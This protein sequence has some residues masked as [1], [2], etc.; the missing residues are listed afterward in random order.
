MSRKAP[1]ELW[2]AAEVADHLGFTG[3]HAAATARST[4]SRWSISAAAYQQNKLGRPEARY[5][6]GQVRQAAAQRRKAHPDQPA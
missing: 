3:D 1:R 2:S 6:A 5:D 4:L